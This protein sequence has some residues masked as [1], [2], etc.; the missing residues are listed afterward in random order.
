MRTLRILVAEDDDQNQAMMKII[1]DRLGHDVISAWNGL[2][3]LELIKKGGVDLVFMDVHMPEMDGLEAT[4]LIREWENKKKRVPIVI[5]SG[6]VSDDVIDKYKN[7]GADTYI[8]KPFDV[9]RIS[10]LT[11]IIAGDNDQKSSPIKQENIGAF[12]E[13]S[14]LDVDDALPRFDNNIIFFIENLTDFIGSLPVRTEKIENAINTAN[15]I[16]LESFSHNLKG[17]SSN[18]GAKQLSQIASQIEVQAVNNKIRSIKKLFREM[19]HQIF[20]LTEIASKFI[21]NQKLVASDQVER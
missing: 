9:K 15:L 13:T 8:T 20:T 10:L 4:R 5:L 11:Q 7:A 16:E 6:S 12:P 17:V 1:L 3:A 14:I 19:K 21:D 2:S 18:F